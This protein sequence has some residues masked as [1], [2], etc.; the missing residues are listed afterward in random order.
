GGSLSGSESAPDECGL[1]KSL[2]NVSFTPLHGLPE[3]KASLHPPLIIHTAATPMPIP[4]N[5]LFGDMPMACESRRGSSVSENP[6]SSDLKSMPS[7]RNSPHSSWGAVCSW[8]SRRSSWNSIGRAPSIK[9]HVQSG[10]HK[11]LLSADGKES[12]EGE[13]SDEEGPSR[14]GSSCSVMEL[15]GK[16][17]PL[18]TLHIPYTFGLPN[19][20][21]LPVDYQGCNGK[22]ILPTSSPQHHIEETKV[23]YSSNLDDDANMVVALNLCFGGKAYLRSSW[24]ILD[25]MLVLISVIDILVSMVSDSGTKILGMLRVL[26]L[27]RTLRPL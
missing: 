8:N 3:V 27:L 9:R 24:N 16:R 1:R 6:Y 19:K 26:R 10:E 23:D 20:H 18:D 12:S 25:G 21:S 4:K 2:S 17:D 15:V 22:S 5:T 7:A 11:S 13:T 14:K